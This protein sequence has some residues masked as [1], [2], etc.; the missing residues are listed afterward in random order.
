ME[1]VRLDRIRIV[2]IA[3]KTTN[4]NQQSAQDIPALWKRFWEENVMNAVPDRSGDEIYCVYTQYE[5]DFTRPYTTII[6]CPV[7]SFPHEMPSGLTGLTIEPGKYARL[8]GRGKLAEGVVSRIWTQ[9]WQ[10]DLDRTY[11]ADFE[12]YGPKAT[13]PDHAEVDVY[14]G[15]R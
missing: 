9:I 13:D 11:R 4:Q 7:K 5:G 2:G 10:S 8:T 12:V 14:V 6:G 3:T 1:I 15:I